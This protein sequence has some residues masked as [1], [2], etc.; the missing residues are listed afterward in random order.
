MTT[1]APCMRPPAARHRSVRQRDCSEIA[2]LAVRSLYDELSLYPKPGLVSLVDNG[3]HDDMNAATFMRS[4][5]S[6]RSYFFRIAAAGAAGAPFD[7]LRQLGIAAERRMLAATGGINTHRGAIFCI[8]MLCAAAGH[9]KALGLPTTPDTMRAVLLREWGTELAVHAGANGASHGLAMA[10]RHGAGGAREEAALGL[11]S[12]FIVALPALRRAQEA[13]GCWDRARLQALFALMADVSDTNVY[14][15]GGAAGA[16]L[17]R[18]LARRFIERGGVGRV[19]CLRYAS[20]CHRIFSRRRL[21]P[22]GAADLLAAACLLH[23]LDGH[24][25]AGDHE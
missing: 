25:Q 8:G 23:R 13:T 17:V 18:G 3:S 7:E 4:L 24:A 20:A 16:A 14:Y 19:D 22:G 15:R 9:C 5:F 2:R 6:L 21:S 1:L 12:V 11:P 10:A